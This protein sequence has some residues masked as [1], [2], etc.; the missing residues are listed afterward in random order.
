MEISGQEAIYKR[1][2][3]KAGNLRDDQSDLEKKLRY[4]QGN[5]DQNKKDQLALTQDMTNIH[6]DNDALTKAQKKMNKLLDDQASLE[7]K[8]R[9]YQ[10]DQDQNKKDQD[11]A[12]AEVQKQQ[13]VLDSMKARRK[14]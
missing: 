4:A 11:A 6:G 7:K 12:Q 8:I 5:L 1:A 10:A 3:K 13:Q 2:L 9:K 14:S